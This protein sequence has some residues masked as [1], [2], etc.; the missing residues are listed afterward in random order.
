VSEL[1]AEGP[2]FD[3][4]A[5]GD[6]FDTAPPAVLSDGAAAVHASIVGERLRMA[7]DPH[8]GRAVTGEQRPPASPSLVWDLAIGQST[9]VTHHVKANLFYR[10][11]ALRRLPALGDVLRT[12]TQVVG[13]RQ[14]RTRPARAPTGLV[15]LRI[16]TVDQSDRTVLDFW[17]C[18]MLPLREPAA[19]TGHADDLSAVGA[20]VD[21]PGA[22]AAA[23]DL[24]AFRDGLPVSLRGRAVEPG[25]TVR[26]VGGDV[27]SSA[28]ELA[29]LTLNVARTHSDDEAGE[30]L[31]Y[32][33]HTIGLAL[34]QA[35]RALPELVTV[36]A[37]HGCDHTG[38]VREG[39]TLTSTVAVE[40]VEPGPAGGRLVHL[41]SVVAAR[42][43]PAGEPRDVLDWRYVALLP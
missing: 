16:T 20:G 14:N 28:P 11:L 12:R 17:R 13:L 18:A 15:A 10:G 21:D 42:S 40:R 8:L 27:V 25:T 2:C 23:W 3:D 38:P 26:V 35:V 29:R 5:R 41:R 30:R 37:W 43:G 22:G 6:V 39:D 9:P 19:E 32:G 33:G 34:T 4:L 24:T 31:V 7:L 1:V 36:V